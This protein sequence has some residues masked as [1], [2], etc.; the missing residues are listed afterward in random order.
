LEGNEMGTVWRGGA[1]EGNTLGSPDATQGEYESCEEAF[2]KGQ[3]VGGLQQ[4]LL[5]GGVD[6]VVDVASFSFPSTMDKAIMNDYLVTCTQQ[7]TVAGPLPTR[8][9]VLFK[10]NPQNMIH[11]GLNGLSG[12]YTKIQ[13]LTVPY[14]FAVDTQQTEWQLELLHTIKT[15]APPGRGLDMHEFPSSGRAF[16]FAVSSDYNGNSTAPR[17]DSL[18]TIYEYNSPLHKF[19]LK[20]N[21]TLRSPGM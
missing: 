7:G 3:E 16:L 13:E 2:E 10:R 5:I 14:C 21:F 12:Q 19:E 1:L 15:H 9:V 8:E 18:S 20:Q 6:G 17:V 4:T 11:S